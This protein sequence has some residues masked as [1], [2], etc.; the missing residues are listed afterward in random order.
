MKRTI[1]SLFMLLAMSVMTA[2]AQAQRFYDE[3]A[4][5]IAQIDSAVQVAKV[6]DKYVICQVGGNW[7][8]WCR[9]FGKF[10]K[11]DADI[12]KVINDNF[13]YVH[14]NYSKGTDPKTRRAM[15]RLKNPGRFGFPVLVILDGDGNVIHIQ[16][17]VY[18]EEGEG[19]NKERVLD[20]LQHW[21]PEAVHTIK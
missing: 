2:S 20:F 15:E 16:S 17:S 6:Q 18:L 10:V 19:Y 14:I 1:L 8:K 21:T 7:C 13:V 12:A 4:D 3:Q 5:Q 11:D 9:W